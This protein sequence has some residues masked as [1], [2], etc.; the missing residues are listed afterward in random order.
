M[1]QEA[2]ESG[3]PA[4]LAAPQRLAYVMFT[5]GSTG[6]PKGAMVETRGMMNHLTSKIPTLDL[7][8]SD[9]VAQTA[10][11]CFDISVWQCLTPLLCGAQVQILPDEVVRDPQRLL[12]EVSTHR[13]SVLE[14]VP[15]LLAGLLDGVPPA[16]PHLRWLLPTGKPCRRLCPAGGSPGFRRFRCLMHMAPPNVRTM[17][18]WLVSVKRPQNARPAC[19]SA[20]RSRAYDYMSWMAVSR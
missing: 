8:P 17:W 13:V 7:G 2:C 10:S 19:R 6:T 16:L 14:V 1:S 20:G 15:S 3:N 4:P 5:S 18:P 9:V 12:A 11:H